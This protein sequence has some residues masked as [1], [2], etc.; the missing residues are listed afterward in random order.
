[1][2]KILHCAPHFLFIFYL[3]QTSTSVAAAQEYSRKGKNFCLTLHQ[4]RCL[5]QLVKHFLLME[6][7]VE[8][9]SSEMLLLPCFSE[10]KNVQGNVHFPS[11][12]FKRIVIEIKYIK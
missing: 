4:L 6:E 2:L 10:N 3:K 5:S 8:E 11:F 1:M 12:S 7:K 9:L